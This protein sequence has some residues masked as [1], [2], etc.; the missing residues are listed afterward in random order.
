MFSYL[1]SALLGDESLRL[2]AERFREAAKMGN[3][4]D[5][6]RLYNCHGGNIVNSRGYHGW[7]ALHLAS[8]CGKLEVVKYLAEVVGADVHSQT[9]DGDTPLHVAPVFGQ[10]ELV[11]YL[12]EKAGANVHA[13]N[14][15][16]ETILHC[17]SGKGGLDIVKYL[18]E[19]CGADIH[20]VSKDGETILH[21]A[22]SMACMF[23]DVGAC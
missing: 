18:V 17:A 20:A 21:F 10:L 13:A 6:Q 8:F 14:K 15:R 2:D 1:F 11:K 3:L 19:Q 12:V 9:R 5:I 22:I 7:T 16:G 23:E 4:D